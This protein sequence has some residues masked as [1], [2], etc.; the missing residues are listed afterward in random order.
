MASVRCIEV[1]AR[2]TECLDVTSV[3][4]FSSS[5]HLLRRCFKRLWPHDDHGEGHPSSSR[6][7]S[8]KSVAPHYLHSFPPCVSFST[9]PV[10]Y[11]MMHSHIRTEAEHEA[12]RRGGWTLSRSWIR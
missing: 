10:T 5:S 12:G 7:S 9:L 11:A 1:Q 8:P 4:S 2:P 6:D 3:T